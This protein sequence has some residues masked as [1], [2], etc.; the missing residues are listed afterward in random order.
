MS[1]YLRTLK[2]LGGKLSAAGEPVKEE[3]NVVSYPAWS[4]YW[5][6]LFQITI[7]ARGCPIT[8]YELCTFLESE[9]INMAYNL[10]RQPP[11]NT[12]ALA[13]RTWT[14]TQEEEEVLINF[15]EIMAS[16]ATGEDI[17]GLA[18]KFFFF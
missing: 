6:W 13:A 16:Q 5:I 4:S 1:D 15:S 10:A 17:L 12:R 2:D 7:R 9:E 8:Y 3:D 14:N 18:N 11:T